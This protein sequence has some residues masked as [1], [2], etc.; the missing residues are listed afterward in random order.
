MSLPLPARV[1]IKE[2]ISN[3]AQQ[4]G[5]AVA[6]TAAKRQRL[7]AVRVS[8]RCC[9]MVGPRSDEVYHAPGRWLPP[10]GVPYAKLQQPTDKLDAQ[11]DVWASHYHPLIHKAF[12]KSGCNTL[13][14]FAALGA[15]EDHILREFLFLSFFKYRSI[16]ETTS[17]D[18]V[19]VDDKLAG[20]I[21][22]RPLV[23][24]K[25]SRIL[26]DLYD[27][28]VADGLPGACLVSYKIEWVLADGDFGRA[29]VNGQS[30]L[31]Y[32]LPKDLPPK[33]AQHHASDLAAMADEE[34]AFDQ[35]CGEDDDGEGLGCDL[36]ADL[37]NIMAMDPDPETSDIYAG[38][39]GAGEE[40]VAGGGVQLAGAGLDEPATREG[41]EATD[42]SLKK[43]AL[44]IVALWKAE[45][46]ASREAMDLH[47]ESSSAIKPHQK[48]LSLVRSEYKDEQEL[49]HV[50]FSFVHWIW[51]TT[52]TPKPSDCDFMI[53][54]EVNIRDSYVIYSTEAF[55]PKRSFRT[56]VVVLADCGVCMVKAKTN[57][58]RSQMPQ[59]ILRLQKMFA[60]GCIA[61]HTERCDW[62]DA[63]MPGCEQLQKAA[64]G[65]PVAFQCGFCLMDV[66]KACQDTL[67][68]AGVIAAITQRSRKS[69]P[70]VVKSAVFLDDT[71]CA[72]CKQALEICASRC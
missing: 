27:V 25:S 24:R 50:K 18:A 66:H 71:L 7:A 6:G 28:I 1:T 59:P 52:H 11:R 3:E 54:R 42:H 46:A 38:V 45:F 65:A 53:G 58:L 70:Y 21:L 67:T 17:S 44:A 34:H 5:A 9:A 56:D 22:K 61:F 72:L 47:I 19:F 35:G 33:A 23:P 13:F 36:E 62:C 64:A 15:G 41:L 43:T 39:A 8:Q 12:S 60:G 32:R 10:L 48:T 69:K 55:Q 26:R 4:L 37:G 29:V 57:S 2:A 16:A 68:M 14:G 30:S 20:I 40:V 63:H 51:P 49:A 31:L